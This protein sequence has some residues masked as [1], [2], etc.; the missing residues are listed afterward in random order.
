[1]ERIEDVSPGTRRPG[2]API[3]PTTVVKQGTTNGEA[4]LAIA[5][6]ASTENV[7]IKPAVSATA[8]ETWRATV[9]LHPADTARLRALAARG[10]VIVQSFVKEIAASGELSLVFFD[11]VYSH[12]ARKLS[13]G[14]EIFARKPTTA[15]CS[16]VAEPTA[17]NHP[18][19]RKR[20]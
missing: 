8:Y 12:A 11:G 13:T 10:D 9:P 17:G 19:R 16:R 14:K 2:R 18:A 7:V 6:L 4:T 15:A 1:M 3:P 20:S 5:A